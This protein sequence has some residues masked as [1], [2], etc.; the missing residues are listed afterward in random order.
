MKRLGEVL[1]IVDNLLIIRADKALDHGTLRE[2]SV[3]FTKK[4]RKIGRVRELFGPVSAPY[5]SIKVSKEIATSELVNLK[6]ERVYLQSS[7]G[8][9]PK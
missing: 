6:N 1:H 8:R 3:V 9:V 2:N 7:E 4:M 5:I